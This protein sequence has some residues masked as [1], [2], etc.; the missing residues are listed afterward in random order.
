MD[1]AGLLFLLTVL[2]CGVALIDKLFFA[3]KRGE[4]KRPWIIETAYALY[5]VF[6]IVFV[7]RTFIA[8]PYRIPTGSMKPT[9]LEGDFVLVSKSKYGWWFP[10]IDYRLNPFNEPERGDVIVF[11][12]PPKPKVNYI[13]RIIGLP[14]DEILY[15]N[16]QLFINGALVAKEYLETTYN[17]SPRTRPYL[18][19]VYEEFLLPNT[20][21][22]IYEREGRI[23]G[24]AGTVPEDH[25]FVMGD[26]RGDSEDS[27]VWGFVPEYYVKGK[28]ARIML[29]Y[30]G[31]KVRLRLNRTGSKIE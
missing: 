16:N 2:S 17:D 25:Y 8:E 22:L 28:A 13:K 19:R 9:L 29:S 7:I 12:Y 26:N 14:G 20:D 5:P 31:G 11:R 1:F 24:F 21:H 23:I 4:K 10:I 15:D 6:L 18:V 3:K 27:R 30:D